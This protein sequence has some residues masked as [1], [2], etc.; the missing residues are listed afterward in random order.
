MSVDLRRAASDYLDERRARGYQLV[1][2]HSL[3]NKFLNGLETRG[4]TTVTLCDAL[5]FAQEP[6]N[7][8]RQWRAQRLAVIRNVAAYVHSLD[9]T[10]AELIPPKMIRSQ[11]TRRIPYLYSSDQVAQLMKMTATL[12]PPHVAATMRT[13]IGLLAATGLRSGEAVALNVSDL[14]V[15]EGV[16]HV[17]GKYAKPRVIPLHSTTVDALCAYLVLRADVASSTNALLV[18]CRGGRL[19]VTTARRT[20]R[21]LVDTAHLAARPGGA[22]PRLHDLRHVFAVNSL[23]DA[24]RRGGDVDATIAAL[25]SYLGHVDPKSTYWYL[26]ASPELMTVV[27]ERI[28][29]YHGRLS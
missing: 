29:T 27:S 17:M 14:R 5:A 4:V 3:I 1:G 18:G 15:D 21:V 22:T 9:P 20:F 24:Y 11:V 28:A 10:S 25:V 7:I 16:L 23:I 8:S 26:S 12:R 2:Y 6:A 13:L 19:D